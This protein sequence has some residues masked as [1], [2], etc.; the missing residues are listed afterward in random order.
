VDGIALAQAIASSYP[1]IP[2]LLTTGYVRRT[3]PDL[4]WPVLRKPYDVAALD[5]AIQETV[6]NHECA[7]AAVAR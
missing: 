3:D 6:E 2:V 1:T 5:K 4:S 7:K